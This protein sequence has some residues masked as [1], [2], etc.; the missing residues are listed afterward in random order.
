MENWDTHGRKRCVSDRGSSIFLTSTIG[1]GSNQT[2]SI[3]MALRCFL[4]PEC[5]C[6][7]SSV[8]W[9]VVEGAEGLSVPHESCEKLQKHENTHIIQSQKKKKKKKGIRC[10]NGQ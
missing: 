8:N 1:K 2:T 6:A 3:T 5:N 4:G 9:A 7:I 10:Q